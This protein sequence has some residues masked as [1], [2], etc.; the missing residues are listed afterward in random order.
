VTRLFEPRRLALPV[1][2][3]EAEVVDVQL[4]GDTMLVT[5]Q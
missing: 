5:V 3:E 4:G 2:M 1:G